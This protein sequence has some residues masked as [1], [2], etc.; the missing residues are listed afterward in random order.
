M[1]PELG[2]GDSE[3]LLYISKKSKSIIL[4]VQIPHLWIVSGGSQSGK[5]HYWIRKKRRYCFACGQY[6]FIPRH[7]IWS[8]STTK[9]NS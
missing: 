4:C 1:S 3:I 9:S 8:L 2:K 6:R 7:Q 5:G